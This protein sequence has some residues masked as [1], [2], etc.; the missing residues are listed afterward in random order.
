MDWSPASLTS[1]PS[2]LPVAPLSE[3]IPLPDPSF[4]PDLATLPSD[5]VTILSLPSAGAVK[6]SVLHSPE[7]HNC[8]PS[9]S[10]WSSSI[11]PPSIIGRLTKQSALP[12]FPKLTNPGP[13]TELQRPYLLTATLV[14]GC[15][16]YGVPRTPWHSGHLSHNDNRSFQTPSEH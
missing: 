3:L 12:R 10:G 1:Q 15:P 8:W 9:T 11:L 7:D 16:L 4:T 6:V 13:S 14:A 2:C 5:G